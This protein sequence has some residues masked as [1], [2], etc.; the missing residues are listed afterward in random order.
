MLNFGLKLKS[1]TKLT[2]E[3]KVWDQSLV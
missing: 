1:T 3:T 2:A